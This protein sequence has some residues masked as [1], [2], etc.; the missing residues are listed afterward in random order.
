MSVTLRPI[1][2][3]DPVRAQ[4]AAWFARLRADD[5]TDAQ[6][7]Q[8]RAWLATDPR[9]RQAYER[10]EHLWSTLGNHAPQPEITRRMTP[11]ATT[12]TVARA[13]RSRLRWAGTAAAVTLLAMTAW[14]ILRPVEPAPATYVTAV[15]EHRSMVLADG[16][17][18]TLDTDTHLTVAYTGHARDLALERG[19]AFF[20]VATDP[21]P[22]SVHTVHGSVRALGTEFEVSWHPD[23]LEVSLI[24]GQLLLQPAVQGQQVAT[25]MHAGQR[26]R[27]D[28]ESTAYH[29]EAI[30]PV[31]PAW[32]SGRLVFVDASLDEVVSE[33]G[34]Y[35]HRALVLEGDRLDDIRIS[36]VF[37]SD[38]LQTFLGALA[39]T[40]PVAVDTSVDGVL[41]L[42]ETETPARRE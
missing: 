18:V 19:R 16:T 6:I 1:E 40:Y 21:R 9:H 30:R 14:A 4:A 13:G 33:F 24:E 35:S 28:A 17:R 8:C 37:R 12:G 41:R 38:G 2:G 10:L 7:R 26:V 15:G 25:A 42:H 22:L 23:T 36:G 32:L 39:D 5:V 20:D 11:P 3:G 34:R 27:F 29:M 31:P